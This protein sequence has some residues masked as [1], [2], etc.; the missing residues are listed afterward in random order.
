MENS[1]AE[2]AGY[3]WLSAHYSIQ[4]VQRFRIESQIGASR[5][6]GIS[7]GFMQ[8]V[9]PA[10]FRPLPNLQGHLQ[11]ALKH[12]SIQLEFLSRLFHAIAP[13][14][15]TAWIR[16]EPTGAY[17]RRAG[18]FYE[19]LTGRT[20]DVGDVPAGNYVDAVNG[21]TYFCAVNPANNKRWR[22]RD[23]LPGTSEFCP[24]VFRSDSV[25]LAEKYDCAKALEKLEAEYGEDVLMRSAV[26]LT[27]KESR[28]SFTIEHEE[29]Q[30]DRIKRFAAVMD[31]RCGHAKAPLSQHTLTELQAAIL[32]KVAIRYG[33]RRSPVF[34]GH[35][36]AYANVV[37]YIAPHWDATQG[38]LNGLRATIT[39]TVGQSPIV[40]A[41]I[42]SFGFVY[43]HPMS[44]GNGRISRFLVNDMLR[45]DGALPAP[46]ILPI[47][48]TITHTARA[49][50]GYDRS[51]EIFSKPLMQKYAQ[52]YEFSN[53]TRYEDGIESNF[54]FNGYDDAMFAW[55]YPDLSSHVAYLSTVIQQTISEEMADEARYLHSVHTARSEIKNWMEGPDSDIDRIIRSVREN[56]WLVSNKLRKEFPLLAA[57]ELCDRIAGIIE[58]AFDNSRAR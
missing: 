52:Q 24:T 58:K 33:L 6:S 18:F 20:L 1:S 22:V 56:N 4:P 36:S 53:V 42:A 49:R 3:K 13:N 43:I 39:R 28:A 34:V 46:F 32:G 17:A 50:A 47:S 44:D 9:Y 26:W 51:L 2:W 38:L 11:F 5:R 23:N 37:D 7:D 40:R 31:S 48:A 45:R 57:Q 12:E 30:I 15:I 54:N 8:E 41:A 19:W 29:M 10:S 25:K 21:E 16:Q 35:T 27:I 14:E 55:K